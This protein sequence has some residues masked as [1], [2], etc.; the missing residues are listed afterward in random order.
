M[1]ELSHYRIPHKA[2]HVD[3][4]RITSLSCKRDYKKDPNIKALVEREHI[5]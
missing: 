1:G 2:H 5:H 4:R 3:L